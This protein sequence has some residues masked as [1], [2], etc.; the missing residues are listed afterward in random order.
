[1]KLELFW[2]KR[3]RKVP[4][5][6]N[7]EDKNW[8]FPVSILSDIIPKFPPHSHAQMI[9]RSQ[10][11]RRGQIP[12]LHCS[13]SE[14]E[15]SPRCLP[16]ARWTALP[17][18][19][20]VEIK[21]NFYSFVIFVSLLGPCLGMPSREKRRKR[22]IT[23]PKSLWI[24]RKW[25]ISAPKIWLFFQLLRKLLRFCSFVNI[26]QDVL[27]ALA[28]VIIWSLSYWVIL[29]GINEENY[30]D[31]TTW[32]GSSRVRMKYYLWVKVHANV[33]C[34]NRRWR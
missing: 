19:C 3:W 8:F 21:W 1:M 15:S 11:R 25:L 13:A 26:P 6:K 22:T 24:S 12:P 34:Q 2:I 14:R 30:L 16:P 33:C 20:W 7:E 4:L 29:L 27:C 28:V 23:P 32:T 10:G 18:S 5:F 9:K 17:R 31:S